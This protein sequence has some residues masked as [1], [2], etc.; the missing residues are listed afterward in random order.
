MKTIAIISI[1]SFFLICSFK[2]TK[3]FILIDTVDLNV[4]RILIN[5][6]ESVN[7]VYIDTNL[8][9]INNFSEKNKYTITFSNEKEFN[10]NLF[11][12]IIIKRKRGLEKFVRWRF[13]KNLTYFK[14]KIS[15]L[16]LINNG[17]YYW[18]C[19]GPGVG[20]CKEEYSTDSINFTHKTKVEIIEL[21]GIYENVVS[22]LPNEIK[23]EILKK[24]YV[25]KTNTDNIR[26]KILED[27]VRNGC[28]PYMFSNPN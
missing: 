15:N 17:V 19:F 16:E 13:A 28:T 23:H 20:D 21:Y 4:K 3:D 5:N 6:K 7:I 2:D 24:K 25:I 18:Y 10:L 11:D 27:T 9:L 26:N 1:V 14:L 22:R 12:T 8:V